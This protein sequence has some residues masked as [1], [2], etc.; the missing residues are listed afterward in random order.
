MIAFNHRAIP[1]APQLE[2][3]AQIFQPFRSFCSNYNLLQQDTSRMVGGLS[4]DHAQ[5]WIF[6]RQSDKVIQLNNTSRFLPGTYGHTLGEVYRTWCSVTWA[7]T[8]TR[9]R[10][11]IPTTVMPLL[12][13]RT[14]LPWQ[15]TIVAHRI[16]MCK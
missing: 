13:W 9:R 14:H 15:V 5:A 11:V 6:G 4:A 8:S 2:F 12:H 16:L 3:L 10:L 7:S 1:P